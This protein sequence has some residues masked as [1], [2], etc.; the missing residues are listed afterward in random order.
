MK[1]GPN[2]VHPENVEI[3]RQDGTVIKTTVGFSTDPNRRAQSAEALR[4]QYRAKS[5]KI[6]G[7]H[8][9]NWGTYT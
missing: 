7:Q 6:I 3:T 8:D 5:V 1:R 2:Q 4:K 9:E